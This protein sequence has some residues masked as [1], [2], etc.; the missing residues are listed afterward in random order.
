MTVNPVALVVIGLGAVIGAL[1]G[2]VLV[3]LAIALG[4]VFLASMKQ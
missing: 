3:G 4:W 2:S 1:F